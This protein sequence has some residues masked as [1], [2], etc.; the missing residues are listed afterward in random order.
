[1]PV[2]KRSTTLT[3]TIQVSTPAGALGAA[4]PNPIFQG[5]EVQFSVTWPPSPPLS[6]VPGTITDAWTITPASQTPTSYVYHNVERL[7]DASG[8]FAGE[9]VWDTSEVEP[10]TYDVS[11]TLGDGV[12]SETLPTTKS[13]D[14]LNP[15]QVTVKLR[16][17]ASGD[18]IP[19][20]MTR[21]SEPPTSDA[22]LW[23]AIRYSA[24]QLS[25][26]N[27]I[28]FAD[29]IMCNNNGGTI[30]NV[31]DGYLNGNGCLPPLAQR[32]FTPFPNMDAY[33]VLK[34]ATECFMMLNCGVYL[35]PDML[36]RLVNNQV[37]ASNHPVPGVPFPPPVFDVSDDAA[38]LNQSITSLPEQ[39]TNWWNVYLQSANQNLNSKDPQSLI[40]PYLALVRSRLKDL[41][42]T[43]VCQMGMECYGILQRKLTNPCLIELIWSYWHEEAMLVQTLNA[44]SRRFQNLRG[45]SD[46]DPLTRFDI[47]PL[48]RLNSFL[49]GYVQDEQHRLTVVRRAY[50]YSHEYGLAL[51]GRAVRAMRPSDNR[52]KFLEAFHN[53]LYLCTIFF[54]EDD[55][56]TV[57]ADGF[58]LLNALREVH[59]ILAA[60]AHNQFGELPSTARQ[61][62]LMQQWLLARP[63]MREF[64]G[65]KIM[66]PY[67]EDW[68]DRVDSV[69]NMEGWTDVSVV[70]FHDLAVYGEQIVLSIRYGA[71]SLTT[72]TA[73][74]AANWARYWRNEIQGYIHAYRAA[75]GVDLTS[76]PVNSTLPSVLLL[77]RL[78]TQRPMARL[79]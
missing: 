39:I 68:M 77:R 38:R 26:P 35:E 31:I 78:A 62:M 45:P 47:D 56:T 24:N 69:K 74:Q 64:L 67:P 43:T 16:P 28:K 10:G 5:Q 21:A 2:T 11:V 49:W 46:R 48:R 8:N 13:T 58:P 6:Q 73:T 42:L 79:G 34:I 59:Y 18:V 51:E 1:M 36:S 25:F 3:R 32:R 44:I 15:S 19:V 20:T 22:A 70:H 61:E 75:T 63:E 23:V 12:N 30:D 52:S 71:W 65:G 14:V 29:T 57:V 7:V 60:G 40:I 37:T 53:L 66:V 27:F 41:P 54:K 9:F 17:I 4:A 76:E 50:E 55:D 72:A 33:R